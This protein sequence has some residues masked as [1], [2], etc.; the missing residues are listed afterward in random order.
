MKMFDE[1]RK[2]FSSKEDDSNMAIPNTFIIGNEPKP[3]KR[4][5]TKEIEKKVGE[6]LKEFGFKK[7]SVFFVKKISPTIT[8][9]IA[10][11]MTSYYSPHRWV[12]INL[13]VENSELSEIASKIAGP[14]PDNKWYQ[15]HLQSCHA[16][17]LGPQGYMT[18]WEFRSDEDYSGVLDDLINTIKEKGFP[19]L[20]RLSTIDG[21]ISYLEEYQSQLLLL[22]VCYYHKGEKQK[23]IDML[24][25]SIEELKSDPL[26]SDPRSA[27]Y[28][29]IKSLSEFLQKIKALDKQEYL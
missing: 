5:F 18:E 19:I 21:M 26:S 25:Q 3:K 9:Y 6:R 16:S 17:S 15:K 24:E 20:E 7:S 28:K 27:G 23:A 22:S 29:E 11:C 10:C 14:D 13:H 8:W 1:I 2:L 12:Q 4:N